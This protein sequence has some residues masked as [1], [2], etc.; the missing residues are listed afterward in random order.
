[1]FKKSTRVLLITMIMFVL[2][3]ATYAFA[4][5]NT[6]PA[7]Y[8]GD[9]EEDISGYIISNVHYALTGSDITG[10]TFT[11]DNDAA[12]VNVG[13]VDGGTMYTC[14]VSGGTSVTCTIAAG[15][16]SVLDADMLRVVAAQ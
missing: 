14:S 15:A 2:A 12:T 16:V 8:A 10:V 13:L 9:G 4:A 7:S 5:A 11:L 6:V 1:M 3:G